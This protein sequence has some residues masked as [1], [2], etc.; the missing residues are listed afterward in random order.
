MIEIE[1]LHRFTW[2]HLSV[3]PERRFREGHRRCHQVN[4]CAFGESRLGTCS[5]DISVCS[6]VNF[7]RNFS[8]VCET[9]GIVLRD[10]Q[11]SSCVVASGV[12]VFL[13]VVVVVLCVVTVSIGVVN[14]GVVGLFVWAVLNV[15]VDAV[16]GGVFV[17][18]LMVI[19]V[20]VVSLFVGCLFVV[21]V[22]VDE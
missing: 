6:F 11:S 20:V 10:S 4:S 14:I 3:E 5:S 9:S 18:R 2:Y 16:C 19:D 7:I 15:V 8:D 22:Y 17:V 21:E 12:I 13:L 1:K